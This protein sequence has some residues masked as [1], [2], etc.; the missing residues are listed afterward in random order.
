MVWVNARVTLEEVVPG[1]KQLYGMKT[2]IDLRAFSNVSRMVAQA[3]GRDVSWQ[4]SIVGEGVFTHEAGI[5][6]DGLIKDVHNYQ[7]LD[8]AEFGRCHQVV[9]GKHSGTRAVQKVYADMGLFVDRANAG[10]ILSEIR[11]FVTRGKRIPQRDDLENIYY[12][13]LGTEVIENCSL[14]T[15]NESCSREAHAC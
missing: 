10:L 9:L 7:S 14:E 8:P 13:Y 12:Q 2:D 15:D 5:H 6:V 11:S 4:K 3:S 1:L